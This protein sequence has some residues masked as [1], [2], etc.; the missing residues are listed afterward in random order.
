MIDAIIARTD[1]VPLF[2]EELTKAVLESG[3]CARPSDAYRARRAAAAGSP[4]PTSL[5]DSLMAR[6]DRWQ[7]VKE[8]AQTAAVIGRDFDYAT[9]AALSPLAEAELTAAMHRLVEAELVFRRGAP[10]DASYLLQA[11]AGP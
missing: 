4:I 7:P 8:V 3:S 1:G 2:V 5:H 11:R 10:P 6:L 9:V